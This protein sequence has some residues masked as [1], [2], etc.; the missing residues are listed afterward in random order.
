MRRKNVIDLH[1]LPTCLNISRE[2]WIATSPELRD[3]I[4]R[5]WQELQQGISVRKDRICGREKS[6][7]AKSA[8]DS[9]FALHELDMAIW[10]R[11]DNTALQKEAAAL[12]ERLAPDMER[13]QLVLDRD[14]SLAEFHQRAKA[15]GT[16][17]ADALRQYVGLESMIRQDPVKGLEL[18]LKRSGVDPVDFATV[19]LA[20][21]QLAH[22]TL[23]PQAAVAIRREPDKDWNGLHFGFMADEVER[24]RP[25]C[26]VMMPDGFRAVNYD[27]LSK[28]PEARSLPVYCYQ[29]KDGG[30]G[31]VPDAV[32]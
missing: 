25:D 12:R 22:H 20:G 19:A 28:T 2:A 29:Y 17:V 27:R 18:L 3:E 31:R 30:D 23:L 1:P 9:F 24:V 16:T 7:R 8:G 13:V 14:E 5:A 15:A 4:I 6:H 26:V 10:R 21:V 11:P 32:A